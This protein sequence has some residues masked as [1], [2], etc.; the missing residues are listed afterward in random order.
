MS[1]TDADKSIRSLFDDDPIAANL[2]AITVSLV[3]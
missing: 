1:V 2:T 3:Q